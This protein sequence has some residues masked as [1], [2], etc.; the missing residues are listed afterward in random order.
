[1]STSD[2]MS[3]E[4]E[5]TKALT[6]IPFARKNIRSVFYYLNKAPGGFHQTLNFVVGHV[7]KSDEDGQIQ[8]LTTL[9]SVIRDFAPSVDLDNLLYKH[10]FPKSLADSMQFQ[11]KLAEISIQRK[12]EQGN[13]NYAF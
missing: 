10:N 3:Y 2:I 1:M 6:N 11:F 8:A 5:I 13:Y 9:R 7:A 4:Q 12:I